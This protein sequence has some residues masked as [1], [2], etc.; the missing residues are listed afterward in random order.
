MAGGDWQDE[1]N[2]AVVADY[3]A[4]LAKETAG[5]PLN[6]ADHNRALQQATGRGRGSIE[7]KHQNV[8]A[9]LKSL[10]ETWIDGYKP[11]FNYQRSLEAA[12]VRW[13]DA[14]P[15]WL[16]RLSAW[17]D[18]PGWAEA[19]ALWIGPPPTHSNAAP[20]DELEQVMAVARRYNVA[21][22]DARNRALGRA[23]EQLALEHERQSLVTAGRSDL[24]RKVL[25]ISDEEGDGSGFD[26]ASFG[27]DGKVRLI[28]VKTTN[29]WERTPFHISANELAVADNRREEWCLLRL[30]NFSRAPRAFELYP[31]LDAH[32]DLT[33][34]S[35]RADFH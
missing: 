35:F 9:V 11:A 10:G 17:Q 27:P 12:V 29:G 2:D 21:E 32:V 30:W 8:S 28:E 16:Q 1:E 22:R 25:W 31:P 5:Q 26:I 7:Y 19:N 13:L 23:G 14:H 20:P 33:P 24:A 4:M 34:T 15:D 18:V 3:F 6:K